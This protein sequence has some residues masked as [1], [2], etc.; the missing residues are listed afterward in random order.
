MESAVREFWKVFGGCF[1]GLLK[2]PLVGRWSA[3]ESFWERNIHSEEVMLL[4]HNVLAFLKRFW[5]GFG[6]G[7]GG[8]ISFFGR[9]L[10]WVWRVTH[11]VFG[12]SHTRP[13]PS[14]E[15]T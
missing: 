6:G 5:K 8:A 14:P 13:P 3:I 9:C 7:F 2:G 1:D 4:F 12:G 11:I 15:R 10:E